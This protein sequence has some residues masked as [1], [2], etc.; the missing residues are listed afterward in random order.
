VGRLVYVLG[1]NFH[2]FRHL[3]LSFLLIGL[4][5]ETEIGI[6]MDFYPIENASLI[7]NRS[8]EPNGWAILFW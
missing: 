2:L 4:N 5:R 7:V 1:L 8:P 6:V 3:A